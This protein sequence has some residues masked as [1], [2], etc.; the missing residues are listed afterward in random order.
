[1]A[2]SVESG[3]LATQIFREKFKNKDIKIAISSRSIKK[4]RSKKKYFER[5]GINLKLITLPSYLAPSAFIILDDK[6][7]LKEIQRPL[8][9]NEDT[10][11]ISHTIDKELKIW[12][13]CM[14]EPWSCYKAFHDPKQKSR[15]HVIRKRKQI[16]WV[17]PNKTKF[18][19]YVEENKYKKREEE[20]SQQ[21]IEKEAI[22]TKPTT[23][24]EPKTQETSNVEHQEENIKS[25][26]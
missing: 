6:E 8:E 25:S 19:K 17:L 22:D 16:P 18:Q 23:P 2:Y 24:E 12:N 1:M 5:I 13:Y 10:I 26:E 4:P 7:V 11:V 3:D 15:R 14:S 9:I 20:K 21:E